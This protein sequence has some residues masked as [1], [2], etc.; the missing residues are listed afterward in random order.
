[1]T[2]FIGL[3]LRKT[4]FICTPGSLHNRLDKD[5]KVYLVERHAILKERLKAGQKDMVSR[6]CEWSLAIGIVDKMIAV[7]YILL[8]TIWNI[9][10][11]LFIYILHQVFN[12]KNPNSIV[13]RYCAM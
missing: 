5:V 8:Q 6:Q 12:S 4:T 3:L 13:K 9:L 7:Q 10:T 11:N 1:M 2:T